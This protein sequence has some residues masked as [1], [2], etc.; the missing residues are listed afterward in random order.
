MGICKAS[1]L[2]TAAI[3]LGCNPAFAQDSADAQGA[4]PQAGPVNPGDSR[5]IEEIVVTAQKRS[6]RLQDIPASITA[7]S[8]DQIEAQG[9]NAT[10]DLPRLTPGLTFGSTAAWT[11][12]YIRGIGNSIAT[13]AAQAPVAVYVDGVYQADTAAM[14]LGLDDVERLEIL[15]GPQGTLYG[16]NAVGG[17]INIITRTPS[18]DLDF[19]LKASYGNFDN[20]QFSAY[21]SGGT[22]LIQTSVTFNRH[23]RDGYYKNVAGGT[24]LNDIDSSA[25][26]G[27][28]RLTPSDAVELTLA[29]DYSLQKGNG[30]GTTNLPFLP[31][32]GVIPTGQLLGGTVP[33]EPWRTSNLADLSSRARDKGLALTGRF[34][35]GPVS[36]VSI[37]ALRK[38]DNS[39][40]VD[41]DATDVTAAEWRSESFHEQFSQ[42]LQVISSDSSAFDWIFGLYYLDEKA[43]MA[44]F[45]YNSFANYGG[46][47]ILIETAVKS[48]SYAGYFEGTYRFSDALSVIG[49]LRYS[50]DESRHYLSRQTLTLPAPP[51]VVGYVD[52]SGSEA[53]WDAFT[54][55]VSVKYERP[56]GLYYVTASKGYN[57]GLYNIT[58]IAPTTAQDVPV[59]PQKID[60]VEVGAKWAFLGNSLQINLAGFYYHLKDLQTF[61]IAGNATTSFQNATARI[62]GIDFDAQWRVA[63][64]ISLRGAFEI[65]DG[66]YTSYQNAAIWTPNPDQGNLAVPPC[67]GQAGATPFDA[68]CQAGVD[69]SGARLLRSPKFTSTVGFDAGLPVLPED[70]G[71]LTLT[72]NWYHSASYWVSVNGSIVSP[73]YDSLSASLNFTTSDEHYRI[74]LWG[75]N[76]TNAKYYATGGDGNYGRAIMLGEPRMYGVTVS[77][78]FGN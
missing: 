18:K 17:A 47:N 45:D 3:I 11:N 66:H 37:T 58:S 16:R 13:P 44:P 5:G 46:V 28:I 38:F 55:R 33:T 14:A 63:E 31:S 59:Q 22:D 77:T 20:R 60:A 52:S 15:K 61:A 6:E 10:I 39:H 24:D 23:Q 26:R 48:K 69:L 36:V 8:A 43:G 12:F 1:L 9:I 32:E 34:D 78:H 76:L 67:G 68:Q 53:S 42:E 30:P 41:F 29:G 62:K 56:E 49:G 40:G 57:A 65:L 51:I 50:K 75:N 21:L 64:N 4:G 35:L 7:V 74:S 71:S 70:M 25:W 19:R 72:G 54:P 27:K 2:A 73:A